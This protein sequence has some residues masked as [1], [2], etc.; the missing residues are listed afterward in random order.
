MSGV[1]N[2]VFDTTGVGYCDPM[3]TMP[4]IADVN[5]ALVKGRIKGVT[6]T[7]L[8]EVELPK[9][10]ASYEVTVSGLA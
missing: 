1:Q 4:K 10:V 5:A 9:A 6:V 7:S 3:K 2:L 8:Q